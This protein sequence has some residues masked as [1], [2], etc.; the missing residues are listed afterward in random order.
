MAE[1]SICRRLPIVHRAMVHPKYPGLIGL[2]EEMSGI[3]KP[4]RVH[5]C[6][7]SRHPFHEIPPGYFRHGRS[8]QSSQR[9][10][11][12]RGE[13]SPGIQTTAGSKSQ[14]CPLHSPKFPYPTRLPFLPYFP[15][16]FH[17][18]TQLER[19][20]MPSSGATTR[21]NCS[22]WLSHLTEEH[23]LG[24]VSELLRDRVSLRGAG[25]RGSV[26]EQP[27]LVSEMGTRD[28]L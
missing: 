14:Q 6:S 26:S 3:Q 23:R 19:V 27:A 21:Q 13:N 15:L 9:G 28:Q 10:E 20:R 11:P 22:R 12:S 2:G 24:A 1:R 5:K 4:A 25:E 16:V 8:L 7:G 17:P 18:T